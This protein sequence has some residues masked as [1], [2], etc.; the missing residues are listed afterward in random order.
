MPGKPADF[1]AGLCAITAP[2]TNL[3]QSVRYAVVEIGGRGRPLIICSASIRDRDN[4]PPRMQI[5]RWR[6][7]FAQLAIMDSGHP[8]AVS[9][10]PPPCGS[11]SCAGPSG[12]LG[13]PCTRDAGRSNA[14]ARGPAATCGAHVPSWQP[15][16]LPTP[17][18]KAL[19]SSCC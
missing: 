5:S 16:L 1:F 4:A 15:S 12:R 3:Y 18:S 7:P 17:F 13:S 10:A 8:G 6:R 14:S 9:R 19:P 2:T 11:G